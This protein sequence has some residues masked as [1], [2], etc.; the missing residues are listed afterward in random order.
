MMAS[1]KFT[2]L[3]HKLIH[4]ILGFEQGEEN[5]ERSEQYILSN[6]LYHNH[7]VS[8]FIF[9]TKLTNTNNLLE[10]SKWKFIVFHTYELRPNDFS[11]S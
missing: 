10:L 6:L 4:H 8:K 1:R 3:S 5:F 9:Y 2:E 7:L 11:G